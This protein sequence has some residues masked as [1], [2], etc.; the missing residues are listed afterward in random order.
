[1]P[2]GPSTYD[3]NFGLGFTVSG[4]VTGGGGVGKIGNDTNPDNPKGK[5]TMYQY[6]S[7]YIESN[8]QVL[9]DKL[10]E[11]DLN[12][13]SYYGAGKSAFSWYDH[14]DSPTPGKLIT[15]YKR[16]MGF[17]GFRLVFRTASTFVAKRLARFLDSTGNGPFSGRKAMVITNES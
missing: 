4:T 10:F 5:W 6:V 9:R 14:P 16:K 11:P 15:G 17:Q 8:G 1:M 2:N 12:T 3:G 13:K 7:D